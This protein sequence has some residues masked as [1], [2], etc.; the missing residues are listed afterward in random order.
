MIPAD[1]Y[2]RHA[3]ELSRQAV[4]FAA[5]IADVL[6]AKDGNFIKP[7]AY[8]LLELPG[9]SM[10][11]FA[12]EFYG[13]YEPAAHSAQPKIYAKPPVRL[14]LIHGQLVNVLGSVVPL[15]DSL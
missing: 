11:E 3:E 1:P 5:D 12:W 6:S 15:E 13:T 2:Q 4:P 8:L 7:C 9:F 10:S 14:S